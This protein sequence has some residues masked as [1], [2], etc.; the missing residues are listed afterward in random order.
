MSVQVYS[1][2]Y[3]GPHFDYG[4]NTRDSAV[5]RGP[6]ADTVSTSDDEDS[7]FAGTENETLLKEIE[8]MKLKNVRM[9]GQIRRN[10]LKASAKVMR[11][12]KGAVAYEKDLGQELQKKRRE[13]QAHNVEKEWQ[14]AK[15]EGSGF[16]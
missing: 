7:D 12:L 9:N 6:R 3:D 5:G 10:Q 11:E 14:L 8:D 16:E 2:Q 13:Q 4:P 15:S 1:D